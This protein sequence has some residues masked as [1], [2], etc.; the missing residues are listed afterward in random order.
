MRNRSLILF[1]TIA[2]SLALAVNAAAQQV[3]V[4]GALTPTVEAGGWLI[5]D[6]SQKYLL[7]NAGDYSSL[8]WF[9][10]GTR[11]QSVGE[12]KPGTITIY[13]EGTPFEASSLTPIQSGSNPASR[14]GTIT[15]SGNA[16]VTATP[17][18]AILSISLVTQN[19]S[20]LEA[21]QLN[22]SQSTTVINA[23]KS[24]VPA[25]EVKT[26]GYALIPQRVY[27][28]NQPP[29]I[30]GYEARNTVTVTLT[31]LSR[32]GAVI[33][34]AGHAG[35]N[36]IDGVSF[37]LRDDRAARS[38]ALSEATQEAMAKANALAQTLD[39]TVTRIVAVQEGG[40][41]PRPVV[42]FEAM[43]RDAGASTP[44]EPGTLD[45]SADVVLIVEIEKVP[46]R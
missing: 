2:L 25:A 17:D 38:K 1:F 37:T 40:A 32:V 31:D 20:A 30:S 28:E 33:D 41:A 16:R 7:L 43:A 11:V 9:K 24:V 14:P 3:S 44:I 39:S 12:L 18:T 15:V 27:K 19:A 42:R 10:A 36:N 29:T 45:I 5:A 6:G 21:Q 34:A 13:Q 4:T 35:A 8:S 46:T 22:A 26:S 23:I